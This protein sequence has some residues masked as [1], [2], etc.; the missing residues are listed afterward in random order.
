[1]MEPVFDT[2]LSG[3]PYFISHFGLTLIMLG[4]GVFIYEKI[5][6]YHELELVRQGN[7]AASISMAAGILGLAIPLA[8][9]LEGSISLWD[10]FIWGWVILLIQILAFYFANLVIDNLKERIQNNEIGP[11]ILL[12]AGKISIAL[13]NAAAI[14]DKF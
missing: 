8:S 4:A 6:P 2:L 7:V 11:A 1:M 9:C 12:F 14:S 5:T 3:F 10:I 13:I